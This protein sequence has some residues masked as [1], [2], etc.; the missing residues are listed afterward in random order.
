MKQY[1]WM[2]G[3]LLM[4]TLGCSNAEAAP[5]NYGVITVGYTDFE[6]NDGSDREVAYLSLIHI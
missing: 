1:L 5:E 2:A 6:F 4:G 3:A